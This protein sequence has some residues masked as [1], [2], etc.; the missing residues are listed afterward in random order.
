M[1]AKLLTLYL[2]SPPKSR[3]NNFIFKVSFARQVI[4]WAI[5][6]TLKGILQEKGQKQSVENPPTTDPTNAKAGI[7]FR[8][9]HQYQG[10]DLPTPPSPR[11]IGGPPCSGGCLQRQSTT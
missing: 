1:L 2:P 3:N 9:N 6:I 5:H 7:L 8:C 10:P 11:D 4:V